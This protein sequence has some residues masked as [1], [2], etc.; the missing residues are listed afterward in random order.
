[1]EAILCAG[2]IVVE[3]LLKQEPVCYC[4]AAVERSGLTTVVPE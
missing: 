1:M 4:F 2:L 3:G